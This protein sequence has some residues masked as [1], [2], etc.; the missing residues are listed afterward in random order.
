[1]IEDFE[2]TVVPV[3]R[4][5]FQHQIDFVSAFIDGIQRHKDFLIG[6]KGGW[7]PENQVTRTD[8][9]L[10]I[11]NAE[12][13][14]SPPPITAN[15]AIGTIKVIKHAGCREIWPRRFQMAQFRQPPARIVGIF[16]A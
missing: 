16:R 3:L 9:Y 14:W 7:I 1:M 15:T 8:N 10:I 5:H 12:T 13:Q 4:L 2:E 6:S 11:I